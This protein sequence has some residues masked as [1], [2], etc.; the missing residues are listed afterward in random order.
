VLEHVVDGTTSSLRL[1]FAATSGTPLEIYVPS[2]RFPAGAVI[3]CDGAA[4]DVVTDAVSHVAR[5]R[6]GDG[7][8]ERVV[9]VTAG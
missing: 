1:R 2:R 6:C 8:G 3:T 9:E 4:I 7:A 5:F